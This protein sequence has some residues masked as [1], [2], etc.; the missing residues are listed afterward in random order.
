M[1]A[2]TSAWSSRFIARLAIMAD[3]TT[4]G[5]MPSAR[6]AR[7]LSLVR[8]MCAKSTPRYHGQAPPA[9]RARDGVRNLYEVKTLVNLL[10]RSEGRCETKPLS[11]AIDVAQLAF[12]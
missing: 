5:R 4:I 7:L 11:S 12:T 8:L 3:A 10:L 2:D 9:S 6:R 1:R